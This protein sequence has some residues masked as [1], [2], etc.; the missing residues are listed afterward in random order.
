MRVVVHLLLI[1]LSLMC[2]V[3]LLLILAVSFTSEQSVALHGYKLLPDKFSLES[4]SYVLKTSSS[5]LNAYSVTVFVTVI[6]TI[7]SVF[8]TALFAYPLSRRDVK[9]R[10]PVALFVFFTMLFNGGLVPFYILIT[11]YLHLK[12]SIFVLIIPYLISAWN[13]MLMRN[14]FQ[15][16][17][18]EIIESAY[19]DGASEIRIFLRIILPLSMPSL[20]TIGLFNAVAYWNDWWLGLLFIENVKLYPLQYLLQAVMG[21]I[22]ALQSFSFTKDKIVDLPSETARMALCILA[23]GPII[24][25]YPFMQKYFVQGL[26]LGAVKS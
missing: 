24:L 19:I 10:N 25:A 26:T 18:D 21:N 4:Y 5:L 17:P 12:N 22:Q 3:P 8:F 6:G 16:I 2:V 1:L 20:A 15:T 13:V 14:F 7:V 11:Q 23:I 9:Y